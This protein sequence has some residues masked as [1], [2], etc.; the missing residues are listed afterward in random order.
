MDNRNP[1][2]RGP[3][4]YRNQNIQ[5]H[6]RQMGWPQRGGQ[7]RQRGR[8][9][10]GYKPSG[11][12]NQQGAK[13]K[14]LKFENDFDFEQANTKFEELRSQLGKV[15]CWNFVTHLISFIV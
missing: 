2:N 14:P 13:S 10:G 6:Q 8:P 12:P 3:G 1:Q 15:I 5:Q 9:R 4:N 7:M 11:Q